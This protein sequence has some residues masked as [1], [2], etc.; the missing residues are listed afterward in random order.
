M[1]HILRRELANYSSYTIDFQSL[2]SG[3]NRF[4]F[5]VLRE[6]FELWQESEIKDGTGIIELTVIKNGNIATAETKI[7]A[8]VVCQCD[9]CL[10]PVDVDVEWNG[11]CIIKVSDVEG[12]Y[13]GDFIWI[14]PSENMIDLAQYFYESVVLGLPICRTHVS[15]DLCNPDVIKYINK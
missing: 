9:R 12:E 10:D 8:V 14:K 15:E 6:L 13:D 4:S 7:K 2:K 11:T 5:P 1:H 3:E